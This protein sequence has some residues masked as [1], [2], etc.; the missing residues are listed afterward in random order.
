MLEQE[1]K[2]E[3]YAPYRVKR[4]REEH[5]EIAQALSDHQREARKILANYVPDDEVVAEII[6]SQKDL[7]QVTDR[8]DFDLVEDCFNKALDAAYI[9]GNAMG[10]TFP[11]PIDFLTAGKILEKEQSLRPNDSKLPIEAQLWVLGVTEY[12]LSNTKNMP[13][14][15]HRGAATTLFSLSLDIE[16]ERA[17]LHEVRDA[18]AKLD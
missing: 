14:E 12:T 5:G 2:Q 17:A 16:K 13:K 11:H 4:S 3:I 9:P 8:T 6:S 18:A 10:K 1:Y 15:K 7:A